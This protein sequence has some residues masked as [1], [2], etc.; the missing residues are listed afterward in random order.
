MIIYIKN[1]IINKLKLGDFLKNNSKKSESKSQSQKS[2]IFTSDNKNN[3]ECM[4]LKTAGYP[5]DFELMENALEITDKRLFEQYAR[6]QWLGMEVTSG[7][8]LFDQ[9][10]IPD[11][12]FKVISVKPENSIIS[13]NTKINIIIEKNKDS[14]LK[15]TRSNIKLSDVIGQENAKN[16]IK[17][18]EKFLKKPESFGTWA[19]KNVLF[20]GN[21]GTGK[22][23][24]VKGLAGEVDVPLYLVKAT[25]LIGEHVGDAASK[26]HDLF[27]KASKNSPS[28]IF[29]DE[30]DAIALHRSFQALRGDVSE[31]VNALLTE[32]DGI[33]ENESVITICATN[34]PSSLDNAIRSRF[35]EEIEF[36]LPD[37]NERKEIFE[38][39]IKTLPLE[40]SAD[41]EKLVKLSKNMSGRDIKEKILK[42][43]LHHAIA[44]DKDT[45]DMDDIDYAFKSSK[46][47]TNNVK[48]MFE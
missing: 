5:F 16:K 13:E 8:Y 18:I 12:A 40:C 30:I 25:S 23:M 24:L 36:K 34:N 3:A 35:E 28:I 27:E 38:R 22:T 48:G 6:D 20:Y 15:S 17:V 10:I 29:I 44:S 32:M 2:S 37:D 43:A 14:N 41:I 42:T 11:F 31:I 47:K 9:K 33:E 46:I 7:S 26:I 39:N 1:V 4:V 21:P 45:V 19:P